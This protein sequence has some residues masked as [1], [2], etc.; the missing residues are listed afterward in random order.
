MQLDIISP[1]VIAFISAWVVAHT[2]KFIISQIKR[3]KRSKRSYF[4]ASGGMPSAHS[5]TMVSLAVLI[6]F[7]IGFGSALFAVTALLPMIVMYDAMMVRRSCGEQGLALQEL[8]KEQSSKVKIRYIALGHT[9][10]EVFFGAIL[11]VIIA[12]VVFL[13][14]I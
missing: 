3:E 9:P 5:A 4:Y 11:G 2:I 13:A 8:I 7:K 10:L 12:W 1:Y 14:T 6:G